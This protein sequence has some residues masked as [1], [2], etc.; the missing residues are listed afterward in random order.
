MST[1]SEPSLSLQQDYI[2]NEI[3]PA[4]DPY[5]E[6]ARDVLPEAITERFSLLHKNASEGLRPGRELR[7]QGFKPKHPVVIVP[8]FV[9]SG[10]LLWEGKPCA[11]K[12]FRW[13]LLSSETGGPRLG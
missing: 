4:L 1:V 7:E 12:Y 8:G 5:V 9:T 6:K 11:K 13:G 10:L 3:V 2:S